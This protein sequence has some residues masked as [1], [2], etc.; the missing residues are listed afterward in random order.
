[1]IFIMKV[2]IIIV[3]SYKDDSFFFFL[4][5]GCIDYYCQVDSWLDW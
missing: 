3:N 4:I 2:I 5:T 1:M